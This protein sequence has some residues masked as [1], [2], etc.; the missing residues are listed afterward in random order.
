MRATV[1]LS[2]ASFDNPEKELAGTTTSKRAPPYDR[3]DGMPL[4]E[5]RVV[6][7]KYGG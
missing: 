4:G 7:E 5:G 3:V 2:A 6:A 1:V